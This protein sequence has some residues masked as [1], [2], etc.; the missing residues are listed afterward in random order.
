MVRYA[1][2]HGC[3]PTGLK[4]WTLVV[5]K[6]GRVDFF[7]FYKEL[8]AGDFDSGWGDNTPLKDPPESLD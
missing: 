5:Y 3:D 2:E 8:P 6:D 1:K 4:D 7:P